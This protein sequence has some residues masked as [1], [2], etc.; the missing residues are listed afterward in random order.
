MHDDE[1]EVPLELVGRLVAAQFPDWADL[2]L[3]LLLPWG[4][5]NALFRLGV[6][7]LVRLPRTEHVVGQIEKDVRWLPRLAPQ[8][9]VAIPEVLATGVPSA[10]YP[11]TWGIYRWLEGETLPADRL[12]EAAP[13][14]GDLA[15]FLTAL[16]RIRTAGAPP[17]RSRGV[18]LA[19]RDDPVRRALAD[20]DGRIDTR[21][22]D[23]IWKA[24]LRAPE[25]HGPPMWIHGDLMPGNL[26][27]RDGRLSAVIDWSLVCAGDPACDLMAAWMFLGAESRPQLRAALDVDDASWMRGRGWALSCALIALPYYWETNPPFA[28]HAR[29]T[30]AEVLADPG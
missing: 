22:V 18:P 30:L 1:I 27:L 5:D 13:A 29:R 8:L 23:A 21:A 26:I 3:E 11:W 25:W 14:A 20:L 15:R 24:A 2:E 10:D 6:D 16:R 28:A 9:P 19:T 7:K 17:P 12:G 4:T